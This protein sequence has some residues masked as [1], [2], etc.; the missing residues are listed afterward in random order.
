MSTIEYR[1]D[2]KDSFKEQVG[3]W[4]N[5]V[6]MRVPDSIVLPIGSHIDLCDKDEVQKKKKDIEEKILE[7]LTEREDNLKQR[8]E[9][10]KQK[11]QCELYSDQVDK[12]CDL[13]E[14]SLKVLDL[15]PIDC[16]RYDAIIE[17]WLKIL[18]SVRNKDIFRNAVRK[19]P[20][21]YK[22]V[23]N[24]IMDL[25]KTPEVPVH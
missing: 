21:T 9:K 11:T 15:I 17:A 10:L 1:T 20:V 12:L 5:N 25:I 2:D 13:A 22:K 19:L 6:L 7:V 4:I 23:E 24:A 8:L 18:E 3:F 14:Y 16:T